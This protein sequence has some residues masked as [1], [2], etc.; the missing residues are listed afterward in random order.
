MR[1]TIVLLTA[2][3]D[4]MTGELGLCIPGL[5]PSEIVNASLVGDGVAHDLIE[6][7]NGAREIGGIADEM[8]ALGALYF[9]R[10]CTGEINRGR[11]GSA[12]TAEQTIAHDLA[13]M[14]DDWQ[15]GQYLSLKTPRTRPT[16]DDSSLNSIVE[17]ARKYIGDNA[18]EQTRAP[19]WVELRRDYLALCLALMR[20][21]YRKAK[22]KYKNTD[23]ANYLFWDI[24]DAIAPYIKRLEVEG[25]QFRLV[26]GGGNPAYC[27]EYYGEDYEH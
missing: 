7:Q 24:A 4:E 1:R 6:H 3:R 27:D 25:A 18:N 12:Y 5:A 2:R 11:S 26:Y 20:V 23:E 22:R 16:D 15:N 17:W 14:F 10:G 8:E 19:N 21:G 13:R 9:V